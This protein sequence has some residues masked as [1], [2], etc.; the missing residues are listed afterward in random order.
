MKRIPLRNST[1]FALVDDRDYAKLSRFTWHIRRDK[2]TNLAYADRVN[3]R[4]PTSMHRE[5]LPKA[6]M[7]D[8]VNG[9]GL[10]NRRSNIRKCTPMQNMANSR[11]QSGTSSRYKGVSFDK[12]VNKWL[13]KIGY[14]YRTI[15]L[16]VF[17]KERDAAKAYNHAAK[18]LFGKFARINAL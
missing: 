13:A 10:D 5:I 16:G 14:N 2:K 11:K 9:N 18:I 4:V 17:R 1:R 6:A 3:G 15:A 8:H 7:I 12:T